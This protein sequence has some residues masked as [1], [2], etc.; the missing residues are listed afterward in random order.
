[1]VRFLARFLPVAAGAVAGVVASLAVGALHAPPKEAA[2]ENGTKPDSAV[3][4]WPVATADSRVDVLASR[5]TRLE[6][7]ASAASAVPKASASPPLPADPMAGAGDVKSLH[8]R[9]H[10]EQLARHDAEG[11]DPRWSSGAKRAFSEDLGKLASSSG[12][13]VRNIDCRTTMCTA[14]VRWGSYDEALNTY[15]A[16]LHYPYALNCGRQVL[17][18]DPSDPHGEYGTRVVFDCEG[19]RAENP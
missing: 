11:K 10:A 17:L 1:M 7:A 15:G 8:E 6:A 3:T 19:Q 2:V 16:L 13:T 14:D 12:F 9:A 4:M 5:L 18:G